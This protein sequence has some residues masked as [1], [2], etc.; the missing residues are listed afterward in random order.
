MDLMVGKEMCSGKIFQIL[1][2]SN[3]INRIHGTFKVVSPNAES[4]VNSQE[5]FVMSVIVQFG[6]IKG[7]GIE[8][9]WMDIIVWSLGGENCHNGIVGSISFNDNRSIRHPVQEDR[10]SSESIL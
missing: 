9:N 8:C 3:Y 2:I 5:F 1:V 10:S 4:G 7:V 6:G